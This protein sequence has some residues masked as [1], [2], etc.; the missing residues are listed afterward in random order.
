MMKLNSKSDVCPDFKPLKTGYE[1]TSDFVA[2]DTETSGLSKTSAS[3]IQ[4]SA[5]EYHNRKPVD[6]IDFFVNPSNG[7]P[8][9]PEIT[10][11]TGIT[12]ADLAKAEPFSKH[13]NDLLDWLQRKTLV[14]HNLE[15]DLTMLASEFHRLGLT[16]PK[17][18]YY[19]TLT[20][21]HQIVPYLVAPGAYKLENLKDILPE[22]EV[23][24]LTNHNSLND[25][26]M[27]GAIFNYLT[28][29][30]AKATAEN[31]ASLQSKSDPFQIKEL[32]LGGHPVTRYAGK[33]DTE[34]YILYQI[35]DLQG[36]VINS[37][38]CGHWLNK[39]DIIDLFTKGYISSDKFISQRNRLFSGHLILDED[40]QLVFDFPKN[41]VVDNFDVQVEKRDG[42][43]KAGRKYRMF[44]LYGPEL[45]KVVIFDNFLGHEFTADELTELAKGNTISLKNLVS[46]NNHKFD[47]K[48][49]IDSSR[50]E[51][52]LVD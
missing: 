10:E 6:E 23:K 37:L 33:I 17:V 42:V 49:M 26:K 3:I 16:L 34:P 19:D 41:Y 9:D 38:V 51:L 28:E 29:D 18:N 45:D 36:C 14:G 5:V 44:T 1:Q 24:E 31:F 15:F 35:D 20:L 12:P 30:P 8:L 39:N 7:K 50:N 47:S 43:S 4:F 25:T 48:V 32:E 52:T 46:R 27:T 13:V 21:A 2:L 22:S 40:N 11:L